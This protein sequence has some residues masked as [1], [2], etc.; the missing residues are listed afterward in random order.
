MMLRSKRG[1][2]RISWR[3]LA[4]LTLLL[5]IAVPG[6]P[7]EARAAE[8]PYDSG[9]GAFSLRFGARSG[10]LD[11]GRLLGPSHLSLAALEA[12]SR[13][14]SSYDDFIRSLKVRAPELFARPVLLH[15]SASLQ[16][17]SPE[18][19]RALLFGRGAMITFSEDPTRSDR[20]VEILAY[21][22]ERSRFEAA[23]IRF[24]PGARPQFTANPPVCAACHG[25]GNET[26]PLWQPYDLWP[27]AYGSQA[28]LIRGEEQKAYERFRLDG[29]KTG[30]YREL[31]LKPA[32][33]TSAVKLEQLDSF[34][35]YVS[36]LSML[37]MGGE[38][39]RRLGAEHPMRYAI[40]AALNGC[41]LESGTGRRGRAIPIEE[42]VPAHLRAR[43]SAFGD[44]PDASFQV[45]ETLAERKSLVSRI[46]AQ[47]LRFFPEE[48]P[49]FGGTSRLDFEANVVGPARYLIEGLGIDWS[50][51]TLSHGEHRASIQVPALLPL[52]LG[53][54]LAAYEPGVYEELEPERVHNS[55]MHWTVFDCESLK[56]RS[57]EALSAASAAASLRF[58]PL[59]PLSKRIAGSG[60][61]P[62]ARCTQCHVHET[63]Q[64]GAPLLPLDQ[65]AKLAQWLRVDGNLARTSSLIRSGKMPAD[66]R[67]EA[68]DREAL[69]EAFVRIAG[70]GE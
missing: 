67:L 20:E 14:A 47:Y 52:D 68:A 65:S 22:P 19:P 48:R 40:I 60:L 54:A 8:N 49:N 37:R 28:G 46:K 16:H 55:G 70:A 21:D 59:P 36:S 25:R 4:T 17:A 32:R 13:S 43:M 27:G 9:L 23:E 24:S 3:E 51:F 33:G 31:V 56:R 6:N 64:R 2:G 61:A 38:L 5:A 35:Q 7:F 30:V 34:S 11:T 44:A 66:S 15:H 53:T 41:S 50:S 63:A 10:E 42:F 45:R 1:K 18:R 57:L 58:A 26:R 29:S 39:K 62:M 69:V 12:L